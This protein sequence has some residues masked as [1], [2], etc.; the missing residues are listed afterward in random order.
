MN[1]HDQP[2]EL[3][4]WYAEDIDTY[5]GDFYSD[6]IADLSG[7]EQVNGGPAVSPDPTE[8]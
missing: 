3:E 4:Q 5:T 1:T 8:C 2:W 6:V 7:G